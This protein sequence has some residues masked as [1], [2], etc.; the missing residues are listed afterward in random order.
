MEIE[1]SALLPNRLT[2]EERIHFCVG[3]RDSLDV[4][5]KRKLLCPTLIRTPDR[6][7]YTVVTI[8]TELSRFVAFIKPHL[9]LK[10]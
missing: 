7:V 8:P 3:A 2:T 5:E 6:L 9:I 10:H 4:S 1:P